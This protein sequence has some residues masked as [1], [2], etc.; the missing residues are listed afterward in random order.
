MTK[1]RFKKHVASLVTITTLASVG[2]N[3]MLVSAAEENPKVEQEQV[4]TQGDKLVPVEE[5]PK[6][7]QEQVITQGDKLVPVEEIPK[8]EQ[9]QVPP[10]GDALTTAE[11]V[12]TR[13]AQNASARGVT[14]VSVIGW[15]KLNAQ[16]STQKQV[17]LTYTLQYVVKIGLLSKETTYFTFDPKVMPYI[18]KVQYKKKNL[19]SSSWIDMEL[20]NNVASVATTS[21]LNLDLLGLLP[22]D[23]DVRLILKNELKNGTYQ[24]DGLQKANNLIDAEVIKNSEAHA[25]LKV[26]TGDD[27]APNKPIVNKVTDQDTKVTGTGEVGSKVTVTAGDQKYEGKVDGNGNFTVDIPKQKPGTEVTVTLTDDS[28]NISEPTVIIVK[29]ITAPETPVVKEVT[30]ESTKVIGTGEAGS[31]VTVT[32]GDQKYEGMVDGNGNFAVDI[33]KQKPGTEVTVIL[34][35]AAG[36]TSDPSKLIVKDATAPEAPVV[37]GVDEN[38]TKVVG[39][40]EVGSKV[41]VT[42]GNQKYEGKVDGNGNFTVDIPKQKPGTEVTVTL[43]D[44]AGNTS[45]PSKVTVK[46]ATAPEAPVVKGVT[47]KDTK[48][49]GT[50]EAGSK[51]TVTIGNQK[52]EGMVDGNGNF[53]VDIPK[54]KPGTEVTVTLTDAAGNTSNPSKVTVKDV[55]APEAPVV[56]GVTD[57]DTKVTVTG[58]AGS[59]VT[60]TIGGQKYEGKVDGNGNF[61]VDIPKQKPGTEVTVTLTDAAGNT[62][63]PSKVIVSETIA[64]INAK[65]N[66]PLTTSHMYVTGTATEG[67]AKV[68]L[69]INGKFIRTAEIQPDGS[70]RVF[71]DKS[72]RVENN[73][74]KVL[75]LTE[76]GKAGT[77]DTTKIKKANLERLPAPTINPVQEMDN[78][79]IGTIDSK[80]KRVAL[81]VNGKFVRYGA[82]DEATG[83]YKVYKERTLAPAGAEI[84]VLAVDENNIDG[85]SAQTIVLSDTVEVNAPDVKPVFFGDNYV[86]GKYAE[87]T[88]GIKLYI[89]NQFVRYGALDSKNETFKIYLDKT[90]A[91]VGTE[92][93]IIPVSLTG[94]EGTPIIV[95]VK[96][97]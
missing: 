44:A 74:I 23:V 40:G 4:I 72:Y 39:T 94:K 69:Y 31:K 89:N 96:G 77:G 43:T 49:I 97:R 41:T 60:V 46:D 37:K 79:V 91:P 68:A 84:K 25:T 26:G 53:A 42:I 12:P 21:L 56:K 66:K 90:L 32:A 7:E 76:N 78:Y 20:D 35:D 33:P 54:Q 1:R 73:E 34:T 61:T 67:T 83:T 80:A 47:D 71:I 6:V 52:H 51:V 19:L 3:G 93:K 17:D 86:T 13:E 9:G 48:V 24:F 63:N 58:E 70:Y 22:V 62:S 14:T 29:D 18:E 75:P 10:K 65:I 59:K 27:I 92:L 55:T 85:Y 82:I 50:G 88:K 38:D 64:N 81:Y 8:V 28:N 87:G 36:N 11:E 5:N 2:V 30:D 15:S 95:V 16:L 57:E 45:N